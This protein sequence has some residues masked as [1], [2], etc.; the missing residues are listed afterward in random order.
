MVV[1]KEIDP[2]AYGKVL[3]ILYGTMGLVFGAFTTVAALMGF[4]MPDTLGIF[5]LIFGKLAVLS[6]PIFYGVSGYFIG[7]I[8]G[9][10]YNAIV[11]SKKGLRIDLLR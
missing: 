8:T 2:V 5:S 11:G 9:S 4:S 1:I 10:L 3:A 7:L 6:L